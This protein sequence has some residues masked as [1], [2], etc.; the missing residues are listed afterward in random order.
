MLN[1]NRQVNLGCSKYGYQN[2]HSLRGRTFLRKKRDCETGCVPFVLNLKG[3]KNIPDINNSFF[4][5]NKG[6]DFKIAVFGF[7]LSY[8]F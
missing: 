4:S 7:P 2:W 6:Q 3:V 1:E 5:T 8:D